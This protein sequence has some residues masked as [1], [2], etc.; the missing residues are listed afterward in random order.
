MEWEIQWGRVVWAQKLAGSLCCVL[1][2]NTL[3]S[4]TLPT[5]GYR[6]VWADYQGSLMKCWG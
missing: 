2:Q 1:G 5:Q 4:V 6:W 3:L